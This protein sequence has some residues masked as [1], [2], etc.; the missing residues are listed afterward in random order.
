M[1]ELHPHICPYYQYDL[2]S[3]PKIGKS[4]VLGTHTMT[5]LCET[6][7]FPIHLKTRTVI[8]WS[9]MVKLL[10]QGLA[11]FL[12]LEILGALGGKTSRMSAWWRNSRSRWL[13]GCVSK[14]LVVVGCFAK[15]TPARRSVHSQRTNNPVATIGLTAGSIAVRMSRQCNVRV[16]DELVWGPYPVVPP[17]ESK[18][19]PFPSAW[20][21]VN[22]MKVKQRVRPFCATSLT[23][24]CND[25]VSEWEEGRWAS[26]WRTTNGKSA[27]RQCEMKSCSC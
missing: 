22:A 6:K 20:K 14:P 12:P 11:E 13:V 17:L 1:T 25:F 19:F 7:P 8:G 15:L 26:T 24:Q 3:L 18:R 2:G 10:W 5:K 4:R 16:N 21:L 27:H 23:T 9:T